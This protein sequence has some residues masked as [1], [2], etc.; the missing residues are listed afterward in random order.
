MRSNTSCQAEL[1]TGCLCYFPSM[2]REVQMCHSA[3]CA[4]SRG[5][6]FFKTWTIHLEI[7][8]DSW[9]VLEF[10]AATKALFETPASLVIVLQNSLKS[11]I[12]DFKFS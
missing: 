10:G 3:V 8:L 9:T 5:C 12:S 11:Q 7:T 4:E 6:F 2:C 1:R